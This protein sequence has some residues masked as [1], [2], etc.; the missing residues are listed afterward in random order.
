MIRRSAQAGFTFIELM[1][2]VAI[3]GILVVIIMPNIKNYTA[4]AK[5]TEV[6]VALTN[7]RTSVS[8][9]YQSGSSIPPEDWGCDT[10]HKSQYVDQIDVISHP[11]SGEGVVRVRTSPRLGDARVS[12]KDIT[13]APLNRS[14]Q[15]MSADDSGD[16]V[17]RWRCGAVVDG[18][19]AS[20][21][22]MFLPSSCRGV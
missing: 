12:V 4:R 7:C 16:P 15:P 5:V 17:F 6:V 14:G 19:D 10:K 3:M 20:L 22:V 2:V 18:T 9:I 21:D 1:G 8:E 11:V 13:L